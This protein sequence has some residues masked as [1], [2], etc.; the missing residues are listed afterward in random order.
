MRT[1]WQDPAEDTTRPGLVVYRGVQSER[2]RFRVLILVL[3]LALAL[4]A[5]WGLRAVESRRFKTELRQA[6]EDFSARR[7]G[8]AH[9]RL[10]RL[11]RSWPG[12]GEVEYWLGSCEMVKGHDEAALAAWSR[13][14]RLPLA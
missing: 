1:K 6:Q 10:A 13:G 8:A 7:I 2:M 3:G 14:H 9:A 5:W 12:M 11:A 4:A